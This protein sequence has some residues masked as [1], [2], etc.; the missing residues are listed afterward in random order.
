MEGRVKDAS[1]YSW[2]G[3]VMYRLLCRELVA[4]GFG[5]V[6]AVGIVVFE[7]GGAAV[8]ERGCCLTWWQAKMI[9]PDKWQE[10]G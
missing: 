10:R 8:E 9:V 5:A 1:R 3:C 7:T 6:A 2:C 4:A